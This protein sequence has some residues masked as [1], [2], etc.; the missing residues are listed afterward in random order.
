MGEIAG[1]G[2]YWINEYKILKRK[3][4]ALK[5]ENIE[6]K[7]RLDRMKEDTEENVKCNCD[8]C[9]FGESHDYLPNQYWC[10]KSKGGT[11][12]KEYNCKFGEI[13]EERL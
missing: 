3:Y 5:N 9:K 8:I 6:L 2:S 12:D 7:I 10:K 4:D 11:I 13:D 1:L